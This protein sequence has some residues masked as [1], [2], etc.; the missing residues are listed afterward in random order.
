MTIEILE[1]YRGISS[2]IKAIQDEIE[3]LYSPI[4]SPNG[5]TDNTGFSGTPGNPTEQ[6][7]FRILKLKERIAD[8]VTQQSELLEVIEDWIKEIELDEPEIAAIARYHYILGNNWKQ[9]N[10]KVYGY[11][12]Y[13]RARKKIFRYFEKKSLV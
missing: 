4:A 1:K 5:K 3:S 6:A 12:D 11:P 10:L 8:S 13:Y 2:N 7:V 9:T